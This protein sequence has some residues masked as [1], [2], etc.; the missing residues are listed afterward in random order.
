MDSEFYA[1]GILMA[2]KNM[3]KALDNVRLRTYNVL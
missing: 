2:V 1:E 3:P